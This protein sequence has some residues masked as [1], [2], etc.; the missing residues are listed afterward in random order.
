MFDP[1][2]TEHLYIAIAYPNLRMV[3]DGLVGVVIN[4]FHQKQSIHCFCF[5]GG[6]KIIKGLYWDKDGHILLNKG[7]EIQ[8]RA[9]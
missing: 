3:I 1:S 4:L 5:A 6:R 8:L 9:F 7:S 2:K